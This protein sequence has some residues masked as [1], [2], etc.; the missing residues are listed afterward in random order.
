M[1]TFA[2]CPIYVLE[3]K[4]MCILGLFHI[5]LPSYPLLHPPLSLENLGSW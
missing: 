4:L 1:G 5:V 2:A 3:L